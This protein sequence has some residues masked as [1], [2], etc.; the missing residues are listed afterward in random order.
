MTKLIDGE[1]HTIE[2]IIEKYESLVHKVALS[3]SPSDYH[4]RCDLVQVGYIGLMESFK[5]FD[6]NSDV[7]FISFAYKYVRGYMRNLNRENGLV[8]VPAGV[9]ASAWKI[10]K[11][12]LWDSEDSVIAEK[13]GV[14]PR[15]VES[16]RI[17]FSI[18][19]VLSMDADNSDKDEENNLYK[20]VSYEQDLTNP[21]V[22][23]YIEKLN[24]RERCI[25]VRLVMGD[26]YADIGAELGVSRAR[27]G[28]LVKGIRGKVAARIAE[29]NL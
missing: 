15:H 21:N 24:P 18:K 14:E 6:V 28:A 3:L 10:D 13:L 25:V 12:G 20:A 17:F 5:R 4:H 9:K 27:V 11:L 19:S 8:H 26:S 7:K 1:M 22:S 23:Y 2:T 29:E 16:C